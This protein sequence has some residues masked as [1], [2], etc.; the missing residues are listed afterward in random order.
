M[1]A[2][3]VHYACKELHTLES[4]VKL[5]ADIEEAILAHGNSFVI[6][7]LQCQ[8]PCQVMHTLH[9]QHNFMKICSSRYMLAI[10]HIATSNETDW[11][12][13]IICKS[14]PCK[15]AGMPSS[16]N[17][18]FQVRKILKKLWA[19]G[20]DFVQMWLWYVSDEASSQRKDILLLRYGPQLWNHFILFIK[21]MFCSHSEWFVTVKKIANRNRT[22]LELWGEHFLL[23]ALATQHSHCQYFEWNPH[24]WVMVGVFAPISFAVYF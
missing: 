3:L 5:R 19:I 17:Y 21:G 24:H 15:W 1:S 16:S 11:C 2:V 7:L 8:M 4:C 13:H 9:P 18:H 14:P 23:W 20:M 10:L 12:G 6:A 22:A